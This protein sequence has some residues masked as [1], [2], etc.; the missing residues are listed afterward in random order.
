MQKLL[1]MTLNPPLTKSANK[2][3]RIIICAIEMREYSVA[4][5]TFND[6]KESNREAPLSRFL[7]FKVALRNLDDDLGNIREKETLIY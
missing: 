2:F 3:R 7:M 5:E 4:A 6:M 1:G